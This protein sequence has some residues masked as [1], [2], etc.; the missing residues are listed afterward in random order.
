MR[1]NEGGEEPDFGPLDSAP[2]ETTP[3]LMPRGSTINLTTILK[4]PAGA[5]PTK[6]E[7]V[8]TQQLRLDPSVILLP[9]HVTEFLGSDLDPADRRR[10]WTNVFDATAVTSVPSDPRNP[11][12]TTNSISAGDGRF[13]HSRRATQ[14]STPILGTASFSTEVCQTGHPDRIR[15]DDVF[16]VC[17]IQFRLESYTPI[18]GEPDLGGGTTFIPPGS[19]ICDNEPMDFRPYLDAIDDTTGIH[20]FVVANLRR[21]GSPTLLT[22]MRGYDCSSASSLSCG[23]YDETV[24]TPGVARAGQNYIVVDRDVAAS[25]GS[26]VAHELGHFIGLKHTDFGGGCDP[27]ITTSDNIMASQGGSTAALFGTVDLTSIQC[28]R[29]RGAAA[30]WM[31]IYGL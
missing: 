10:Y 22:D 13:Y 9:V 6:Q 16:D 19:F 21:A 20:I 1:V 27:S 29:A 31:T 26:V 11:P 2:L 23:T 28:Q 30:S 12:P 5:N 15:P 17:G 14:V 4:G 24:F 8:H 3:I 7:V 18:A 25:A